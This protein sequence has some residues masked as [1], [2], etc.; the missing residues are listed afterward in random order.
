[1]DEETKAIHLGHPSYVWREGQE[2]RVRLISH[3]VDLCGARVLDAGCGLGL[4]VQRFAELGARAC[5]VDIDPDKVRQARQ[6]RL[7][8]CVASAE[9]LPMVSATIDIVFSHEVLEH[10]GDDRDAVTE[11]YRVLRPGG[12]LVL[13]VPNLWYPFE[14]HGCYWRGAYH[15]GNMPLLGYLPGAARRRLCPHVRSYT[16]GE[17]ARLLSGLGGRTVAHRVI[18]AGYDQIAV[19]RPRLARGLQ[20]VT[21]ALERTPLQNLGLSHLLVFQKAAARSTHVGRSDE[22]QV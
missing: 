10:V 1:M 8:V 16:R 4:Y 7:D 21:Y 9:A 11:A 19:L 5:G 20:R 14:T 3:Y 15:P 13:F 22:S 2:R 18:Y 12:H 6:R 17:L